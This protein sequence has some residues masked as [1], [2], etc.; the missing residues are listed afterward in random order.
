MQVGSQV[1]RQS[2]FWSPSAV[3]VFTR[4]DIRASGAYNLPD[5]LRR[6]PG[7]DIYS[8]KPS[9]SLVGARAMTNV[10]NNLVLLLV[11]GREELIELIL[12]PFAACEIILLI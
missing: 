8:M 2:I 3:T 1:Q 9:Y 11:D 5:L 4:E 7:F 10:Y 6:V 12:R